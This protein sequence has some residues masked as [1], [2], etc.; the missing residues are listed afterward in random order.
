MIKKRFMC[1]FLPLILCAPPAAVMA[2]GAA[3]GQSYMYRMEAGDFGGDFRTPG[4]TYMSQPI[5]VPWDDGHDFQYNL[6]KHETND[7]VIFETRGI[8]G[9]GENGFATITNAVESYFGAD[10]AAFVRDS[11]DYTVLR[12]DSTL[13]PPSQEAGGY[14]LLIV[15]G[16]NQNG[17][18]LS[19]P[20]EPIFLDLADPDPMFQ[21]YADAVIA[22]YGEGIVYGM[23]NQVFA[24]DAYVTR[25]QFAA[26]LARLIGVSESGY[27]GLF[28]DV[29]D[30]RWYTGAAEAVAALGYMTGENGVFRPDDAMSYEDMYAAAYAYLTGGGLLKDYRQDIVI[31]DFMD[32]NNESYDE[33]AKQ[34]INELYARGMIEYHPTLEDARGPGTRLQAAVFINNVRLYIAL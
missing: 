11:F 24:P 6:Y 17:Y 28:S 31:T 9:N 2:D 5:I 29:P 12:A 23:G 8:A 33:Y 18:L 22:L 34:A 19:V 1:L 16:N 20:R 15:S 10:A 3:D 7:S 14:S 21:T 27:R 26:L 13:G 25:A 30:G 32:K 4:K